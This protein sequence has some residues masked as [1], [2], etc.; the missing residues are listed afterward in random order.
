MNNQKVKPSE[1]V[2]VNEQ[3]YGQK[4]VGINFNPSN[5]DAIPDKSVP[6]THTRPFHAAFE[7]DQL[8]PPPLREGTR[9]QESPPS[10]DNP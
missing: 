7:L 9:I 4:A 10:R 8:L 3:T 6:I 5:D 1:L 2:G